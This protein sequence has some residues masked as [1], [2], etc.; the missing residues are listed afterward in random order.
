[1]QLQLVV[2]LHL[3][4]LNGFVDGV[5]S[6]RLADASA[7]VK[8]F[9]SFR[10]ELDRTSGYWEQVRSHAIRQLRARCGS[11]LTGW[12]RSQVWLVLLAACGMGLLTVY[13][14]LE[15]IKRNAEVAEAAG[16][17]LALD[18]QV[19]VSVDKLTTGGLP[20]QL[21]STVLLFCLLS[22]ARVNR[23]IEN[24]PQRLCEISAFG[25][26]KEA[27]EQRHALINELQWLGA[28]LRIAGWHVSDGTLAA[29]ALSVLLP[30]AISLR[31]ALQEVEEV[32]TATQ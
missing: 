16:D 30:I 14:N 11:L 24:I 26:G 19:S 31:D 3:G 32:T 4:Q 2:Q 8:E 10:T 21:F 1:M 20:V 22:V 18:R 5:A 15:A 12:L 25:S 7:A 23:A 13:A 9:R 6:A 29:T 27:V 28:G 17:D